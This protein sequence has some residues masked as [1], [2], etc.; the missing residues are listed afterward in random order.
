MDE[1]YPQILLHLRVGVGGHG[2]T[3]SCLPP[4]I[5]FGGVA[6]FGVA[7]FMRDRGGVFEVCVRGFVVE[8]GGTSPESS[9]WCGG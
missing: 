3:G 6:D 1:L 8:G 7:V 5:L 4:S 2:G 9:S